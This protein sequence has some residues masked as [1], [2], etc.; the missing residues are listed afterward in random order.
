[1]GS[2]CFLTPPGIQML[3]P[4]QY[5][6]NTGELSGNDQSHPSK[7][8]RMPCSPARGVLIICSVC[9]HCGSLIGA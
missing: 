1:M 4:S 5:L 3:C 6:L 8:C 7:A 2:L 9:S